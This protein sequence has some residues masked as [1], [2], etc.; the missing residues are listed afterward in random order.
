MILFTSQLFIYSYILYELI[1]RFNKNDFNLIYFILHFLINLTNTILII[2][3]IYNFIS[4]P[5]FIDNYESYYWL[6][7]LY[8]VLISL[9]NFHMI[10]NLKNINADEIIHHVLTYAF[11]GLILYLKHPIYIASLIIMSGIPGGIT[12][13]MLVLKKLELI[14][15]I[16]EKQISKN[17]NVWIR[18]PGCV[19]FGF[20]YIIRSIYLEYENFYLIL[21]ISIWTMINGIHFMDNICESYYTSINKKFDSKL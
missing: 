8:P 10:H 13:L 15:S 4:D 5:L 2:P 14:K 18:S 16:T 12:Y 20:L 17:L 21:F 1:Y 9:H 3:F 7:Y 19:M 6:E 11:W